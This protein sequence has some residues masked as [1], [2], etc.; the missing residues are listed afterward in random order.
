MWSNLC[1]KD[2]KS[3]SKVPFRCPA[4]P[5]E[6]NTSFN[7]LKLNIYFQNFANRFETIGE[8]LSKDFSKMLSTSPEERFEDYLGKKH[9]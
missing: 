1:Q 9:K 2:L 5:F 3:L 6:V 4:T 7:K 8:R